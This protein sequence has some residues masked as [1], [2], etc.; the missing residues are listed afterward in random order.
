VCG[1]L[2]TQ[3]LTAAELNVS[4]NQLPI[5]LGL[6]LDHYEDVAANLTINEVL[7]GNIPWQRSGQN[8]P[9][10]GISRSAHWFYITLSSTSRIDEN[11]LLS[12]NSAVLDRIEVYMVRNNTIEQQYL[13]GDTI[14]LSQLEYPFRIPAVPL[15]LNTDT[16]PT[17]VLIRATSPAGVEV[18]LTLMT[19]AQFAAQQQGEIAFLGALLALF[20]LCFVSCAILYYFMRDKPFLAF[21]LFFGGAVVFFMAQTGLGRV[22]IWGE[23]SE[24][25][26]RV[27]LF[28]A[29][30]LVASLCLIGQI[31]SLESRYRELIHI[32]LRFTT[33]G[34]LLLSAYFLVIP[35]HQISADNIIPLMLLALLIT[36]TVMIMAGITA[37]Q[38]S[39]TAL[40]LFCSWLL[41]ILAYVS[42]LAYKVN[43]VERAAMIPAAAEVL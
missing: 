14:P 17:R 27:S 1:W 20:F 35:F 38:G 39:K 32:V 37:L 9:T 23:L 28:A 11:L 19:T 8:I 42:F 40:Y 25:N 22:W 29:C 13:A 16:E 24:A 41:L 2:L 43:L 12:L 18:P 5:Q 26:S 34:M 31:I 7:Q 33:Y 4:L 10:L 6:Y 30:I 36:F 21:T 3:S 15:R